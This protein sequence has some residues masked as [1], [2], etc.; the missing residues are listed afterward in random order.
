MSVIS[1]FKNIVSN[2]TLPSLPFRHK[3]PEPN[4]G[5]DEQGFQG[6]KLVGGETVIMKYRDGVGVVLS[7]RITVYRVDETHIRSWCHESDSFQIFPKDQVLSLADLNGEE[8]DNLEE[9]L[10]VILNKDFDIVDRQCNEITVPHL[11]QSQLKRHLVL[12]EIIL[13]RALARVDGRAD[14]SENRIIMSYLTNRLGEMGT[15]LS[16]H[17]KESADRW[18]KR[19][20]P[21][22]FEIEA[23]V[24][25]L[26][27]LSKEGLKKFLSACKDII[28]AD[29]KIMMEEVELYEKL[30]H[31]I[32]GEYRANT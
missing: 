19:I 1:I 26:N 30:G 3:A 9:M 5:D 17:E 18:I 32:I 4:V 16:T 28:T 10:P 2:Q 21:E 22:E 6:E 8:F 14:K 31:A 11:E 27:K 24:P 25:R 12:P 15:E 29:G 20:Y 23:A 7:R 13:L